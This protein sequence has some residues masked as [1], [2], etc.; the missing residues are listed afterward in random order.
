[1]DFEEMQVIWNEQ[2]NEKLYVIDEKTIHNH[3]R[4][5]GKSINHILNTVDWITIGGYIGLAIYLQIKMII[6]QAPFLESIF[7]AMFLVCALLAWRKNR[8]RV[9][10]QVN[11]PRTMLGDLDKAI[12]QANYLLAQQN[13]K[14]FFLYFMPFCASCIAYMVWNNAPFWSILS[15]LFAPLAAYLC[16]KWEHRRFHQPKKEELL[17]LRSKLME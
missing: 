3:I 6:D 12:W 2:N 11:F 14:A 7:P 4:T 17:D 1:M 15:V 9:E 10:L 13:I 8:R 5:K 16:T